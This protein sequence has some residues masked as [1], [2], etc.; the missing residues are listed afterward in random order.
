MKR[1]DDAWN[2]QY[3]ITRRVYDDLDDITWD[4]YQGD[5][6]NQDKKSRVD[7]Y[8]SKLLKLRESIP[9][10]KNHIEQGGI[11]ILVNEYYLKEINQFY[12]TNF[13]CK[14]DED[15]INVINEVINFINKKFNNY[16]KEEI[17]KEL[18]K[19]LF[20]PKNGQ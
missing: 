20:D 14:N 4:L 2:E 12:G 1:T 18:A 3:Y 5:E 6:V 9:Y 19:K 8:T 11:T 16:I 10:F 7:N 17:A 15:Y 13:I